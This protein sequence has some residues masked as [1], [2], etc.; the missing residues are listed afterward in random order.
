MKIDY[1]SFNW[2]V[3]VSHGKPQEKKNVTYYHILE[4][5]NLYLIHS[6]K[7]NSFIFIKSY[8]ILD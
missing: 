4:P 3:F 7:Q 8:T 1:R 2:S 5:C 6:S